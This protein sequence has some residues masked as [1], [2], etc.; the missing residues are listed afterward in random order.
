MA[1]SD[2]VSINKRSSTVDNQSHLDDHKLYPA[3]SRS[4]PDDR[5]MDLEEINALRPILRGWWNRCEK[6]RRARHE[7]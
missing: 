6:G 2:A 4:A 3:G 1:S 5:E 7:G